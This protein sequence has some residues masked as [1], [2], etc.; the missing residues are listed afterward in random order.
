MGRGGHHFSSGHYHRYRHNENSGLPI[1]IAIVL[2]GIL[3][4]IYFIVTAVQMDHIREGN[5]ISGNYDLTKYLYDDA[6]YFNDQREHYVIEGLKYF[7]KTTGAQMVIV[8]YDG[9]MTDELAEK[10][11]Y[12]M[13]DDESHV[14]IVLPI[15]NFFRGN[16]VQYYYIGDE[17][18][19]AIDEKGMNRMLEY[20]EDN[21]FYSKEKRWKKEIASI[22]DLIVS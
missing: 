14:L 8:T 7:Y 18:L 4:G 1:S 3:L 6:N 15:I 17:A 21:L 13:F 10:M 11:Y 12:D 19:K 9:K 5:K 20:I 2:L 16:Y 22:A